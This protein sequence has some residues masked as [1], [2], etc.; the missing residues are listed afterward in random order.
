MKDSP[1]KSFNIPD[2]I[3]EPDPG[4]AFVYTLDLEEKTTKG[5]I[6]VPPKLNI[7][8][9]RQSRVPT[10]VKVKR[11]IL[12]K[13]GYQFQ[14]ALS[15]PVLKITRFT[16]LRIIPRPGDEIIRMEHDEMA[17]RSPKMR[18]PNSLE[19]FELFHNM[20][21]R[22]I[23]FNSQINRPWWEKMAISRILKLKPMCV[24]IL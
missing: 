20:E 23:I 7:A 13:T 15:Y 14:K 9:E 4:S 11:R 21:V 17:S 16:V 19:D 3:M 22:G 2:T 6:I 5:G 24:R 8:Y 12:I 1:K 18:D 10:E